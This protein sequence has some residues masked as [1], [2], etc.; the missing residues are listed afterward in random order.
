MHELEETF[1]AIGHETGA[2]GMDASILD[3]LVKQFHA[4]HPEPMILETDLN[5]VIT[6][7]NDLFAS[8][9]GYSKEE[10]LGNHA[11]ILK[12]S[13][14]DELFGNI[15]QDM[16]NNITVGKAWR[17]NIQNRSKDYETYWI[18]TLIMPVLDETGKPTRYWSLSFDISALMAEKDMAEAKSKEVEESL[19]YAKRIQAT[20]LPSEQDMRERM[21]D[22]YFTVY[23]PKDVVSG[24]FYWFGKTI[25]KTFFAVVDCTG[26]GVPGAFMSL[27]GNNA[28]NQIVLQQN[29]ANA[30]EIL[31]ELHKHIRATLRQD[32]SK[33]K[34]TKDGMDISIIV[35]DRWAEPGEIQYAGANRPL[36]WMNKGELKI[37]QPDK[38]SIGGEQLEEERNF[39]NHRIEVEEGDTIYMFTDGFIDQFGG[40]NN[41]KFSSK[42][43]QQLIREY[44]TNDMKKQKALFNKDFKYWKGDDPQIDDV[45]LF[46]LRFQSE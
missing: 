1:Q 14:M 21:G 12:A 37:I 38:M 25:N 31:D 3:N 7:V 9:S 34:G 32:D 24:D 10:L 18:D 40:P 27:I 41:K 8:R 19:K 15:Y 45:T 36:Y 33:N 13:T 4:F 42:Q 5:G 26:H 43:L 46:G 29:K 44:H 35:F 39:T 30:A 20:I 23:H 2:T 11:R 22:Q 6:D 28:L 17:H 16:W